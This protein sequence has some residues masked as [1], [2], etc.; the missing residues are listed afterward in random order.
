M[1]AL[2][3][4]LAASSPAVRNAAERHTLIELAHVLGEA[5]ALHRV[6]A[7]PT[8]DLW[9]GRMQR[10]IEVEAPSESLKTELTSSFNAGFTAPETQ[11]KDCAA[12]AATERTVSR[13]GAMLASKLGNN[14]Q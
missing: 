6:C 5:H 4:V 14:P 11:A 3:V 13:K 8:D 7:G 10:L 2:I 1:L 12:A 9:R